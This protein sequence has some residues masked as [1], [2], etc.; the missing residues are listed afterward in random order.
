MSKYV[1]RRLN[2]ENRGIDKVTDVL[3]FPSIDF[4]KPSDFSKYVHNGKIDISILNLNNNT[5]FLGDVIICYD[6]VLS[7]AKKYNH[8]IKREYAFLLTH[9]L[10]HLL[11]YDH[12]NEKDENIMFEKQERVLNNLKILR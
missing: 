2:R 3:S 8:S 6:K 12:M 4:N 10:L 7:Q 1:I 11:G 9:S 5:I